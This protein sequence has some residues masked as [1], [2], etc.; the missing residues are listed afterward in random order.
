VASGGFGV[1]Y[2]AEAPDGQRV[3]VKVI[4]SGGA[5]RHLQ[6]FRQEYEKLRQAGRHPNIIQ[7]YDWGNEILDAREYP[8]Y[9]MELSLGGD[10]RRRIDERGGPP[11]RPLLPWADPSLRGEIVREF[12]AVA[13]AAA[14]LHSLDIVHRDIK[15]GNVLLM[16]DGELRL[17]DF[18]LVKN[19]EPS[20]KSLLQGSPTSSGA[21]VGTRNYMAPEQEKGQEVEKTADVYALGILLAELATGRRPDA[22]P[23]T[24]RGSTIPNAQAL[25]GLPRSLV[26]LILRCT[27]VKPDRRPADAQAVL[28]QFVR[29]TGATAG[30]AD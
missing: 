15:P 28:D 7:C 16:D 22:D 26:R 19:L 23:F 21:V 10:L 9:S 25:D 5:S 30:Q 20:E 1:I 12:T 27:D 24:A 3:A 11:Q 4:E 2:A 17:S 6:R 29:L 14:H 8:R 18:G 13:G